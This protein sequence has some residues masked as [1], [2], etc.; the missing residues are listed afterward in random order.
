V[1][2]KAEADFILGTVFTMK[3]HEAEDYV[4]LG[5][6]FQLMDLPKGAWFGPRN[7]ALNSR[8]GQS[9]E[10]N[11]RLLYTAA[12]KARLR[13]FCTD[14]LGVRMEGLTNGPVGLQVRSG[15]AQEVKELVG[16]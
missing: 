12:S 16:T 8:P 3:G 9:K 7:S 13:L 11:A 14:S 6:D 10:A 1:S 4:Q 15:G 2:T 5:K